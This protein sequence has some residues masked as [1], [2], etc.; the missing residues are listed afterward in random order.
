M[1]ILYRRFGT[2]F[3]SHFQGLVSPELLAKPKGIFGS[4]VT[5]LLVKISLFLQ[6][7]TTYFGFLPKL[8]SG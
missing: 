7:R 8:L 3:P 4:V 1:V 2:L 6:L 5:N